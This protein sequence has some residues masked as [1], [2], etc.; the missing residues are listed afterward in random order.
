[1]QSV[2][3]FQSRIR[4]LRRCY[5]H[6]WPGEAKFWDKVNT[7]SDS[8]FHHMMLGGASLCDGAAIKYLKKML[9]RGAVLS[10]DLCTVLN[11]AVELFA[12]N[13]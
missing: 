5:V 11:V 13:K 8:S 3:Y 10:E 6:F 1:M 7:D 9:T 4:T 12:V 2:K